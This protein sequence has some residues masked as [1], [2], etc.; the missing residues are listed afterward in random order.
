LDEKT[1]KLMDE[2]LAAAKPR[3]LHRVLFNLAD[4]YNQSAELA[5]S[6]IPRTGNA[7]FSAPAIMCRSFAIE[8]LLKFFIAADHPSAKTKADLDSLGVSLRGHP[9]SALFD[10]ISS[11]HQDEI[12]A[13]FSEITGKV[14][15]PADFRNILIALGDDPFV[16]W[17]Y[18]YEGTGNSYI[19]MAQLTHVANSLGL[20][21]QATTRSI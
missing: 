12:A 8:L 13:K 21:A 18:V 4:C 3:P 2:A 19:D 5:L 10:R 11:R 7:D 14:T 1:K 15:N 17:R 16:G 6:S 20:A 9:Y